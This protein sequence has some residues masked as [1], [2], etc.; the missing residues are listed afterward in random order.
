VTSAAP[1]RTWRCGP[2]AFRRAVEELRRAGGTI[3]GGD[4]EGTLSAATPLG[5]VKGTYRFDG[6]EL[7]VTITDKPAMLPV[8]LV[9]SRMDQICGSP[10]TRA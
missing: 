8:D 3:A 4:S 9:W 1:A 7:T 5:L 6:E 10:V 2:D